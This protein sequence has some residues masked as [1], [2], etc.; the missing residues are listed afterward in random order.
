MNREI[1]QGPD[2]DT[3]DKDDAA[4]LTQIL[5]SLAPHVAQSCFQSRDSVGWEFHDE[6]SDVL[7]EVE[8]AEHSGRQACNKDACEI[9]THENQCGMIGEEGPNKQHIDRQ[10][11]RTA[12]EGVDQDSDQSA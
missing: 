3:G 7:S 8:A 6:R 2:D 1:V 4:H 11:G 12:D 10:T 9:Q 5:F